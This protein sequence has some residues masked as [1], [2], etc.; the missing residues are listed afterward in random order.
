[1]WIDLVKE[2]TAVLLIKNAGE[3]PWL[4][5]HRLDVLNLDKQNI[6]RLSGF[7]LKW[8]SKVVD[9]GQVDVTHIICAVI[10]AD[11]SSSPVYTLNL[12]HLSV[13][14]RAVSRDY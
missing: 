7:D 2:T 11:L 4:I 5:L 12:D 10:V 3:T 9:F 6:T 13:L 8:T 14:D 1:M